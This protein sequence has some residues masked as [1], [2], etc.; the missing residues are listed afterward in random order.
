MVLAEN[1]SDSS[2]SGEFFKMP[3]NNLAQL[4]RLDRGLEESVP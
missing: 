2:G 3:I 4:R 1:E